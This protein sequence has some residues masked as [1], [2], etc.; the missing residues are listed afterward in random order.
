MP[1]DNARISAQERSARWLCLAVYLLLV[2]W[3]LLSDGTWDDDCASRFANVRHAL[4]DPGQFLDVWN[5]PL[6]TL[7]LVLPFQLGQQMVVW[8]MAGF[9]VLTCY[10][11]YRAG[12]AYGMPRAH[13]LIPFVAFQSFFFPISYSALAE[14]LAALVIAL[15]LW[16]HA[17]RHFTWFALVGSLLPLARLELSLLLGLWGL[18]LLRARKWACIP[19]LATGVVLWNLGGAL[20]SGDPLWL[21]HTIFGSVPSANPYGQ[22]ELSHYPLRLIFYLGPV[23]FYLLILGVTE[24]LATWKADIMVLGQFCLG[25]LIYILFSSTLTLG[26]SAGYVRHLAALA[27]L[28]ALLSLHGFQAWHE[29]PPTRLARLRISLA[30]AVCVV[31]TGLFLSVRLL[32]H[33]DFSTEAEYGKLAIVAGLTGIF[34]LRSLLPD[35]SRLRASLARACAPLV[36]ALALAYTLVTE[37]PHQNMTFEREALAEVA[38]WYLEQDFGQTPVYVNH[39][40]FFYSHDIDRFDSRFKSLSG[41]ELEVAPAGSIVIWESHYGWR[42]D[43]DLHLDFFENN[44]SYQ[45]LRNVLTRDRYFGVFVYRKLD[46]PPLNG[47]PDGS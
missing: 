19:L 38:G 36:V 13:L 14:P 12:R 8:T 21:F 4:V 9:S 10:A 44:N 1:R 35:G 20:S 5:R 17:R 24:K 25:L 6:F 33:L 7:L 46:G 47:A 41:A 23:F 27:P 16:L 18:V 32:H 29:T 42:L 26:K 31:V 3:G 37:P 2:F 45:L 15:G 22:T 34:V 40:W 30:S 11:T 28:A 43:G 39:I